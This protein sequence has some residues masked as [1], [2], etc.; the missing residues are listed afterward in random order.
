MYRMAPEVIA[1]DEN[2][3]AT[4]DYRVREISDHPVP[5]SLVTAIRM[6]LDPD[7]DPYRDTG[8]MYLGGGMHC[9][10]ASS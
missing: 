10:S 8:K 6:T 1:C 5:T 3:G 4:Y 9:P 7:R 2:L